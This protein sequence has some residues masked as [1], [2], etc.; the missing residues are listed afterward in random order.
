MELVTSRLLL[1]EFSESDLDAV[2]AYAA[3]PEVTRFMDWGPNSPE[4]TA[5]FL[6]EVRQDRQ[7]A[8]R[9]AYT[10]AVVVHATGDLVGAIHL[11]E[12]SRAHRRGEMG[13]V[14][15]Q[16]HWRRGYATE[17]AAAI[18]R[19]GFDEVGLR[20]ITATCDP[21]NV[22][23]A[24]VLEKIGMQYEGHLRQHLLIRGQW[25]DRLAFAALSSTH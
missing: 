2:H 7:A 21:D 25:R 20:K 12:T 16:P 24:R 11:E 4:D 8:P 19:F 6:A 1:R 18:L 22:A 3:D 13:Y 9:S 5:A 10:L 14:L 23:S 15:A 17:A